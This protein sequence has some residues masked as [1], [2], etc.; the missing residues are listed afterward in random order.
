MDAKLAGKRF[1][2]VSADKREASLIQSDDEENSLFIEQRHELK[3]T[4]HRIPRALATLDKPYV[5]II[6]GPCAGAGMDMASMCD[7]RIASDNAKFT[8][9]YVKMGLVPGD[10]G[11]YFLPKILGISKALDLIWTG[12]IFGSTEALEMGYVDMVFP[13]D[14]LVD[15]ATDYL[16]QIASGPSVA[17]QVAKRLVYQC[18]EADLNT[19]LD[20]CQY[21]QF[22]A[23]AT[24][25]SKEGPIAFV[26]KRKPEFKGR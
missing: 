3:N 7:I 9:A 21:G 20:L 26:Q 2:E 22:I 10:G 13:Q 25:D 6:N 17:I 19:A 15:Q 11:C 16:L 1:S 8:M 24:E 4:V 18:W 14:Q 12:R 23:R 5:G